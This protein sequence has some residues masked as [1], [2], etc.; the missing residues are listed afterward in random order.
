M[1]GFKLTT[2]EWVTRARAVHG[3]RYDYSQVAY[4][5]AV[6][7]VSIVCRV[8]GAFS[9]RPGNH[10]H[11]A[12]G[13]KECAKESISVAN[14]VYTTDSFIEACKAKS[15][16]L[17]YSFVTCYPG[18][19]GK[20]TVVCPVHGRMEKTAANLLQG[21]GC[22]RCKGGQP[23]KGK[24]YFLDRFQAAHGDRY[25]YS[26][27]P[28]SFTANDKV[29]VICREHG[30]WQV[31]VCGHAAGSGCPVC[32]GRGRWNTQTFKIECQRRYP[33]LDF[34]KAVYTGIVC[35]V[36]VVC[37]KHGGFTAV[38][39]ELLRDRKKRIG[40]GG[41]ACKHCA[42]EGQFGS[43]L[44][45]QT[46]LSRFVKH[47]GDLY[48]YSL[49]PDTI[50]T[51]E[52]IDII[53]RK[54][55]AFSILPHNHKK[56]GGCPKCIGRHRTTE[57]FRAKAQA[58]Y[59]NLDFSQSV[60]TGATNSVD[61]ICPVHGAFTRIANEVIRERTALGEAFGCHQ[62]SVE[63]MAERGG[64]GRTEW[65]E[66]GKGRDACLY[67]IRL[68]D[69]AESFYKVGI[70][71]NLR[72]RF[73]QFPYNVQ[74]V[75]VC[76]SKDAT[77]IWNLEAAIKRAGR[78]RRYNPKLDFAGKRECLAAIDHII[79]SEITP[80]VA[81]GLATLHYPRAEQATLF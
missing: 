49:L 21:S 65:V 22:A 24:Q 75:A 54:H 41:F 4:V 70:T 68:Y 30:E 19:W 69:A 38:A 73:N 17:D 14:K 77:L 1:T 78:E 45:K 66:R 74:T 32:F 8:H 28:E 18:S 15:P 37:P 46:W 25:D 27:L 79:A 36:E 2:E 40:K 12:G 20:V 39:G 13:C 5:N 50:I 44:S 47:H 35:R 10:I 80:L 26:A 71:Y 72:G 57:E 48:D 60:Y 62:C 51:H 31:L 61:I 63:N 29:P 52:K 42:H 6:T 81:R 64:W 59:P 34:S 43:R 7:K 16:E 76:K 11:S 9:I 67:I 23:R 3:D 53:C 58:M 56:A 55:G 33:H